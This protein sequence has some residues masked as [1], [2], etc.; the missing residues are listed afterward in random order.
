MSSAGKIARF[1]R[2][3]NQNLYWVM[4]S[5]RPDPPEAE[6]S[7]DPPLQFVRMRGRQSQVRGAVTVLR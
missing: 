7:L 3:A 1:G 4:I 6:K 5:E 2:G